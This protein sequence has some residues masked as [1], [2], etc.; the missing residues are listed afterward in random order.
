MIQLQRMRI[1]RG[2]V[3]EKVKARSSL[4]SA[5]G[6]HSSHNWEYIGRQPDYMKKKKDGIVLQQGILSSNTHAKNVLTF[7]IK[8][9]SNLDNTL[10]TF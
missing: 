9:L 8:F 3:P 4:R 2:T 5:V 7:M 6:A 10:M 1:V